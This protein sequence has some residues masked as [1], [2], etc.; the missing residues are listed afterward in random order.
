[1]NLF[2]YIG[3]FHPLVIH[4]PIGIL[5]LFVVLGFIIPRK[6]LQDSS[7]IIRW[8]LLISALSATFSVISGLILSKSGEYVATL[9]ANHRNLGFALAI[10]N[11]IVFFTFKKLLNSSQWIYYPSI[12]LMALITVVTGHLGGSITHGSDFITPPKPANWFQSSS[13]LNKQITIHSTA[14]ESALLIFEE[15]CVVCHGQNKQKGELRLDTK[16]GF[17][18]GGE[19]GSLLA[20]NGSES[21][22][23][24]RILLPLDDD[25]HMPP[26]EKKQLTPLEISF[27]SWWIK[28]GADFDKTLE[29]LNFPD[30]LQGFI[31]PVETKPVNKLVPAKEVSSA[32]PNTLKSLRSMNVLFSPIAINSNYLSVS[33]M[34]VLPEDIT[35]AMEECTKLNQQIV[36]INLDFQNPDS[37]AWKQLGSLSNLRKLSAKNSNLDDEIM[38]YLQ[39]LDSLVYLNLVATNVSSVGF[40][41]I[42]NLQN[43]ESIYLYQ[44]SIN[45]NEFRQI[46]QLF[47]K[48]TVDSGNYF[49][50]ILESD[51]TVLRGKR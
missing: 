44:T 46:Q 22:L 20:T 39:L 14:V 48:A 24:K 13:D 29:D 40:E 51:T 36:W 47:P 5:T 6:Q 1:M 12:V 18:K 2:E 4:L 33:F 19:D 15:K 31:A 32:D 30:S 35:T 27:L 49:V 41:N 17:L 23:M 16:E 26:S 38:T 11:W 28:N 45:H 8:I 37:Q 25:D 7:K 34:N 3:K 50:P 10:I 21:L 9:T 42:K 43:L